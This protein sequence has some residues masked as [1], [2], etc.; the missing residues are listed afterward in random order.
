LVF[1]EHRDLR[2]DPKLDIDLMHA[3]SLPEEKP[4]KGN[5]EIF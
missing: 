3:L 2:K 1:S 5:N 4:L